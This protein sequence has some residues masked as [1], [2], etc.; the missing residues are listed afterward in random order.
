MKVIY[1]S[2]TE[3]SA[4]H[5]AGGCVEEHGC[6]IYH[7]YKIRESCTLTFVYS[8]S[9]ECF[10]T[11]CIKNMPESY[12]LSLLEWLN[13]IEI[14]F[15]FA[16]VYP[17]GS[18]KDQLKSYGALTENVT[19]KYTRQ[20]LE[21]VCYLHSNMIVHRDIKGETPIQVRVCCNLSQTCSE[22]HY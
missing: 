9:L 13:G 7:K 4:S 8:I 12:F 21:G 5:Y 6:Q 16:C 11:P 18:I 14:I 17:Q 1:L 19:R 10:P 15:I 20:I 2:C 3:Y 22:G